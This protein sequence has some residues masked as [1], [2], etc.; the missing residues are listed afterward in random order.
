MV[1]EKD[2]LRSAM[3]GGKRWR[4]SEKV[5]AELVAK[6]SLSEVQ[7]EQRER[8]E[9]GTKEKWGVYVGKWWWA[10]GPVRGSQVAG[11]DWAGCVGCYEV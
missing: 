9:M 2:G 8:N 1:A 10:S 3:V 6:F 7:E 5:E 11:G 4:W